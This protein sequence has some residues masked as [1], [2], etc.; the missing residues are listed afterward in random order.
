MHAPFTRPIWSLSTSI[1]MSSDS[2][3]QEWSRLLCIQGPR[4]LKPI[5]LS[6]KKSVFGIYSIPT[7]PPI[8]VFSNRACPLSFDC[9]ANLF[10][11]LNDGRHVYR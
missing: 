6:E 4:S 9:A 8:F 5:Y 7:F 3:G 11:P 2:P 1:T 10:R